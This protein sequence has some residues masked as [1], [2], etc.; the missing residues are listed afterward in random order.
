PATGQLV[1]GTIEEEV[2]RIMENLKAVLIA[3]GVDLRRVVRTTVYLADL[4][5]FDA[6]NAVY[7]RYF[8]ESRPAR[9]TVQVSGLPKG[10]RVE[11]DAVALLG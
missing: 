8:G 7:G 6:M 9:S 5:D 11:I 2:G 10:A 1:R 3:G 4:A